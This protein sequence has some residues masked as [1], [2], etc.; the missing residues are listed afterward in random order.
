M[1][2]FAT[3]SCIVMLALVGASCKSASHATNG[4]ERLHPDKVFTITEEDIARETRQVNSTIKGEWTYSG[5]SVDV[6]G[7]N[8]LA[9]IGKPFAKGKLKKKLKNAYKKIGLNKAKPQ[10]IFNE[11]GTCAIKILGKSLNGSYN[12]NPDTKKVTFKWHG[13][14]LTAQLRRDGKKKLH[15]TF[16]ADKLLKLFSLAGSFSDSSTIKALSTL[17]EYYDDVMVGFEVKK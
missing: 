16:D 8:L 7:K 6:S 4:S 13:I 1:K 12:Y 3:I 5:P 2:R 15:I 17:L 14:P 9:G 10:F 11:D